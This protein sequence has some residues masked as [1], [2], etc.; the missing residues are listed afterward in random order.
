MIVGPPRSGKGVTGRVL[1]RLIGERNTCS[2][3][4]AS[5]GRDF[6]KQVLIGKTLA[7][8]ADARISGR[9]DTAVVAETLLSISGEDAQ[10]VE[11]KFLPDWNGKLAVRFLL[12]TNELPRIGDVSGA[13]AKRFIVLALAKS[14]YGEE[15]L[16]LYDRLLP[17][18]P[19]I[20]NWA[21]E[22]RDRLYE[23]GHFI[24][25]ASAA[26]LMQEMADLGSPEATFLRECTRVE[27]GAL[28]S[29]K[30]LF[31]AWKTWCA[32]NGRDH[33]GTLQ[34]F[35]RNIRAALP[36]GVTTKR[37]GGRG[38]QER[39]WEGLRVEMPGTEDRPGFLTEM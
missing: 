31:E 15:D 19:G 18:L 4:L 7:L 27:R 6:G 34:S 33:V 11:R 3:T 36:A 1:R 25:P 35:G 26:E 20:L 22:G 13:L 24:Q 21:L 12:L 37:V 5:F 9:T 17:E 28:V 32:E 39:H 8:I 16:G 30:A 10:T 2:P 29:H 23:R 14:F 38:E